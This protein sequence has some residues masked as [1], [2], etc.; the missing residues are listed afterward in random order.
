M[1]WLVVT[2]QTAALEKIFHPNPR[3]GFLAEAHRLSGLLAAGQVSAGQ[4]AA[5]QR[6]IFNNRLDAV[7]TALLAS[8]VLVILADSA[9]QWYLLLSRRKPAV[10]CEA[11]FVPSAIAGD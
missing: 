11:A 3:I 8:M 5:T 7:V 6:L 10:L 4:M 2:T 1:L 9:R